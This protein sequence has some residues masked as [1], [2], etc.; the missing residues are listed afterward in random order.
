[1]VEFV[2][3]EL[4]R[5][6]VYPTEYLPGTLRNKLF[7]RGDRLPADHPARRFRYDAQPVVAG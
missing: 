1:V 2:V 7:G 4:R 5:R 3:P 6:G